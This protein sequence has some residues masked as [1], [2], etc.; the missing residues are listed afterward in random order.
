M[1][2]GI[3]V[4]TTAN[5][6]RRFLQTGEAATEH[7]I[8]SLRRSSQMFT[9]KP[10]IIGSATQTEVFARASIVCVEF[11]AAKDLSPYVASPLNLELTVMTPEQLA[12]PV[13]G[14]FEGEH[15]K[16][17]IDF[18]FSGGHVL[19]TLAEGVRKAA[20]AER[21]MNLTS[22]LDRPVMNYRLAHGG[23]GLMNPATIT[24]FLIAPG[25]GDLPRDAWLAESA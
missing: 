4:I 16:V 1:A 14:V 5:R 15:F 18:F 10:L 12:A 23:V 22:F 11:E 13:I 25:A 21:L 17:R 20:L 2:I 7:T 8:D 9:G 24:R 19:H 3:T 6:A